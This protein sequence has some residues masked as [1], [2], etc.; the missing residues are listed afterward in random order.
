MKSCDYCGKENDVVSVFCA[1]CGT[2]LEPPVIRPTPST[3]LSEPTVAVPEPPVI[4]AEPPIL[5]QE[6][7]P[8][9]PPPPCVL[10]GGLA[11]A[12]FGIYFGAQFLG[13]IIMGF[14]VG[15]LN[16][17]EGVSRP[18]SFTDT[19]RQL[20]PFTMFLSMILGGIGVFASAFGFKIPLRDSSP[21][22]AAWV[23]GRWRDIVVGLTLGILVA[24]MWTILFDYVF[25]S[26]ANERIDPFSRVTKMPLLS[27]ALWVIAV[28]FLAP[29][30]E[31][32]LFR[33][34]IFGGFRKSLGPVRAGLL[35]TLLFVAMHFDRLI[36]YPTALFGITTLALAALFMR[37]RTNAIGPSICLHFGYNG[38]ITLIMFYFG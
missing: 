32:L 12:V 1:G 35:T 18:T 27:Q 17:I 10:N 38:F 34:I 33:G 15:F 2:L 11:M 31:E 24:V 16:G 21:T 26:H 14:S 19:L 37:V 22:G 23:R 25:P 4:V 28:V 36:T 30:I 9:L 6:V 7:P 8:L 13:G 29:V 20:L 3:A 5:I